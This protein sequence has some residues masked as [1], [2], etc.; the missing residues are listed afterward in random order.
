M[1]LNYSPD[2]TA[3]E[4]CILREIVDYQDG[5]DRLAHQ[6]ICD[7]RYYRGRL[8]A[9]AQAGGSNKGMARLYR[10]HVHYILAL[11]RTLHEREGADT[12]RSFA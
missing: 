7:L 6:L 8:S 12:R 4:K 1:Q 2:L 5:I 10:S 9:C 3:G 11:L